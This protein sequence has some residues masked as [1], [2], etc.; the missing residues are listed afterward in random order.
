MLVG[1]VFWCDSVSFICGDIWVEKDRHQC[2]ISHFNTPGVQKYDGTPL[3][4]LPRSAR[5]YHIL[6]AAG[7][8]SLSILSKATSFSLMLPFLLHSFGFYGFRS[9]SIS[10]WV[11]RR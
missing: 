1:F 3:S 4:F 8:Q 10:L 2:A 6:P 5:R 7:G 11:S 9:G